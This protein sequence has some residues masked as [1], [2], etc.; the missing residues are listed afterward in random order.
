M[1]LRISTEYTHMEISELQDGQEPCDASGHD[2][3][4]TS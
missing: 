1:Q 2:G 3:F 4:R